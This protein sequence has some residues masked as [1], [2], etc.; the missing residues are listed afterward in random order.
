LS[1]VLR[2]HRVLIV[3]DNFESAAGIEGTAV[4]ANM[5]QEDRSLLA[6]FLDGLRGG[7]TRV[8][9][10]SRST[11]EWLGPQRRFLLL[12]GGMDHEER[13]EYCDAVLHDLAL[14]INREDSNL[15]ELMNQLG[16]H[17]LAMRAILPRLEKMTASHV[18]AAL[19]WNLAALGG[20]ADEALKCVYATL[21]FVQQSLPVNLQ[22]LLIPLRL[23]ENY[24]VT[25][26]VELMAEKADPT[27]TVGQIDCLMQSLAVAGLL[28]EIGQG[29][30]EMHP[31][32]T[33]YLRSSDVTQQ[34]EMGER[35]MQAFVDVMGSL[36]DALAPRE[37]HEQRVHFQLHGQ[38]LY[39]ALEQAERLGMNTHI[40]ALM[41]SIASFA[42]KSRNFADA[43]RLYERLARHDF[44]AGDRDG[45]ASAYHQLGNVA[46]RQRD[47]RAAEGWY[48]KSLEI[49]EREGDEEG[50]AA[51]YHQLGMLAQ[52]RG[53][54]SAE[55]EWYLKSLAI[56][57]KVGNEA[58]M[59]LTYHQLGIVAQELKEFAEAEEW[60]LKSLDL[61]RRLGHE[62]GAAMTLGQLGRIAEQRKDLIAAENR[63]LEAGANFRKVHD[64]ENEAKTY[65]NLGIVARKL[66]DFDAAEEWYRRS[67]A[68]KER[69][70]D[71]Y[72]AAFSYGSLGTLESERGNYL[73]GG[74]WL[75]K[76]ISA[77]KATNDPAG[78]ERNKRNFL[79]ML[80][81]A[82][83][84]EQ[85]QLRAMWE[86]AGLGPLREDA[87]EQ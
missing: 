24:V 7:K 50:A 76:S 78:V 23:H 31:L 25:A 84:E 58:G 46:F 34:A 41:Q 12:L 55:K 59:A 86:Q 15:I 8:I 10:T 87:G 39:Y 42:E 6:G 44:Q 51:T 17:P 64:E 79:I 85:G 20:Q 37:L 73:E 2:Q 81:E 67:L 75:I 33:S 4:S 45:E 82:S 13:W 77:S 56:E 43:A 65:D 60:C 74:R 9:I 21:G 49:K 68:I 35:W 57:E 72:G 48:R 11:E 18:V 22:G 52:Q 54:S 30:Y 47:F 53:N 70:K 16:G 27:C 29:T 71:I 36:G 63:Y 66:A 14:R 32:L 3:W 26:L 28:R 40:G 19:R 38:N 61:E 69:I 5:A 83:P 1:K 62:S 80:P